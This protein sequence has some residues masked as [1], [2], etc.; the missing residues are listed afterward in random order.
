MKHGLSQNILDQLGSVFKKY[1]QIKE[2]WLYGSRAV[3]RFK[4]ESDIDLAIHFST[5]PGRLAPL[6]WDL[7]GLNIINKIDL[8]DYDEITDADLKNEIKRHHTVIYPV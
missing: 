6:R 8:V 5:H 3:G 7:E 1:P 4:P 2:I